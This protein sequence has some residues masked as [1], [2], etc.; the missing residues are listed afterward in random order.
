MV[1]H[2]GRDTRARMI[3][4]AINLSEKYQQEHPEDA[5][6]GD[7]GGVDEIIV[8]DAHA[9]HEPAGRTAMMAL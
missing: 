4:I 6:T 7:G 3:K 9:T 5:R 8:H 1:P 2:S